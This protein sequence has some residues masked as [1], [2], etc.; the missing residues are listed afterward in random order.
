VYGDGRF[1]RWREDLSE[2]FLGP[3][4]SLFG[5]RDGATNNFCDLGSAELL[6]SR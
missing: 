4:E 3:M 6:P 1:E 2:A 5:S